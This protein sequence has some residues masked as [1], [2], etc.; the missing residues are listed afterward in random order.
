MRDFYH[1]M[2]SF[3]QDAAKCFACFLLSSE[4]IA[5]RSDSRMSV[6]PRNFWE[7]RKVSNLAVL[8]ES[9][10][11]FIENCREEKPNRE[12]FSEAM[13]KTGIRSSCVNVAPFYTRKTGRFIASE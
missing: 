12:Q 6:A 1:E 13:N 2:N 4:S 7:G 8:R 10:S 9:I 5:E 3:R 11:H